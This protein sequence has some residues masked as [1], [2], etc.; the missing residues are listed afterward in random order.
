MRRTV[1]ISV[2]IAVLP[3]L[4][5]TA[6]LVLVHPWTA[7]VAYRLPGFPEPRIEM[8]DDERV[9]LARVG[10]H[11]VQP[12]RTAGIDRMREARRDDGLRA[13]VEKEIEHFEDVRR[14]VALSL[15]AGLVAVVAL[16]VAAALVRDRLVFRRGL[17]AGAWVTL[18][19]FA[20]L[21]LLM[22]VGFG[23]FFDTF[24]AVFF[25]GESWRLPNRGTVRSLYPDEYWTLVGGTMATLVLAQAAA[26]VALL[27]RRTRRG[28]GRPATRLPG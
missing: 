21:A 3:L 13:F 19:S 28:R 27:R 9:R 10:I 8:S 16:A 12:W 23:A 5:G 4:V 22:L 7:E 18:A 25:E 11:A 14:I 15:G 6:L 1:L 24:H 26:M 17:L 20:A 2:A